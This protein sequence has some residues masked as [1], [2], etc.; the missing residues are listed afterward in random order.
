MLF[1]NTLLEPNDEWTIEE[2]MHWC[3]LQSQHKTV[4]KRDEIIN[5]YQELFDFGKKEMME[6]QSDVSRVHKEQ[7]MKDSKIDTTTNNNDNNV[8][9]ENLNPNQMNDAA[10]DVMDMSKDTDTVNKNKTPDT[11]HAEVIEGPHKGS[12]FN[13][14]PAQRKPCWIGRSSS[15]KFRDRGMSLNKDAEVSTTHGKFHIHEGK[16]AFTDTG[17]TNGTIYNNEEIVDQVPLELVDGMVLVI[18]NCHVMIHLR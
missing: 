5:A 17:S 12:T 16:L 9:L 15:K 6:L 4:A 13:L 8:D 1:F 18:G 10:S 14:K 7:I 2:L 11:I 3:L